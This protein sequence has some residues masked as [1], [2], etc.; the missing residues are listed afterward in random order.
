MR[1]VLCLVVTATLGGCGSG[2]GG[3]GGDGGVESGAACAE[4]RSCVVAQLTGSSRPTS[5]SCVD[6]EQLPDR[7]CPVGSECVSGYCE[8]PLSGAP[9]SDDDACGSGA[10][11]GCT[12]FVLG[13][14]AAETYCAGALG[15]KFRAESCTFDRE[16]RSGFCIPDRGTCFGRCPT[17]GQACGVGVTCSEVA[18]TVEGTQVTLPS[19][20]RQP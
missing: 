12:P 3:G 7:T 1:A 13:G 5:T 14:G 4:P 9:C 10:S 19:C 20:V 8:A 15:T 6:G 17:V 16:C 18:I 11:L 2:N